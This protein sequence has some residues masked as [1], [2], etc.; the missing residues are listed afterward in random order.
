MFLFTIVSGCQAYSMRLN[1]TRSCGVAI[2]VATLLPAAAAAQ[3]DLGVTANGLGVASGG[4]SSGQT[5]SHSAAL[6]A[7]RALGGPW[8]LRGSVAWTAG[9]SLSAQNVGDVAGVQGT[10]NGGDA[11]WLYEANLQYE[12]DSAALAVGRL[13][14]GD[15]FGAVDG[16]DQFVNAAFSSSGGALSLNDPGRATSPS[17]SWGVAGQYQIETLTLSGGA[18]LSD[19]ARF[20]LRE[21]GVDLAFD[22]ADG[23]IGFAQADWQVDTATRVGVG[24][25]HDTARFQSFDAQTV[26]GN[27]GGYAFVIH[28]GT[29][30]ERALHGFAMVQAAPREDRSLQ[31]FFLIGGLTLD[32]PWPARPDDA[33]SFGVSHGAFS[34]RSALSGAETTFELNYRVQMARQWAVRPDLQYIV[35]AGGGPDA[36]VI[37]AQF[38]LQL[39]SGDPR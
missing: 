17:A 21:H 36:L 12:G 8:R 14:A 11:L 32:A 28:D 19:P 7:T 9:R 16:M 33:V 20:A 37:G 38:E 22:P 23:V 10:F 25:Y 26:R 3:V 6:G 18:F 15:Y 5:Y 24:V 2:V 31:P 13:A 34:D 27:G 35:N 39:Q 1:I 30:F 29:L 4:V